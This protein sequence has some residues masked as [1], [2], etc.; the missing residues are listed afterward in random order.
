M[1]KAV[2]F[3]LD[4][5]LHDYVKIKTK[6]IKASIK[7]MIKAGLKMNEKEAYKKL[8]KIYKK[9]YYESNTIFQDFLEQ[10]YGKL[11]YK[12]LGAA[13]VAYRKVRYL[14]VKPYK[15]VKKIL[16]ELKNKDIR[17]G[18]VTDSPIEKAW[19]RLYNLGIVDYFDLVIGL[20]HNNH[21]KPHPLPF[22]QAIKI[23]KLKPQQVLFV[24]DNPE[25]DILGAQKIGM[26]TA[27]AKYGQFIKGK[28]KPDYELK[29]IKDLIE[30]VFK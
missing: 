13:I 7:A 12:I 18:I 16:R 9:S 8:I 23:L 2:L 28:S 27:L 4:N 1:I 17:L 10:A 15:N 29:D 19:V 26:K 6:C 14:N 11:D 22:K 30:K 21:R 3:D 24:G 5:T 20:K 25:R